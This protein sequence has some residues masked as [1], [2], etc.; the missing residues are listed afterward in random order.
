MKLTANLKNASRAA[1]QWRLLAT[2]IVA[3]LLPTLLLAAPM[4]SS[5]SGIL[6]QSVH[7]PELAKSLDVLSLADIM[8]ELKR[9]SL[10]LQA[11]GIAALVLT[12]LL[13]PLLTGVIVTAGR[14]PETATFRQLF[15]GGV[16][17]YPRMFRTLL[18]A[19]IPLGL[20]LAIGAA[21]AD[22]AQD[23]AEKA[24]LESDADRW[25]LF[26]NVL[27]VLLL[28]LAN[29]TLD[30]GRAQL[31]IDR[32]RTSAVKAWWS[33]LKLLLRRPG[34][35]LGSYALLTVAGL[36]LAGLFVLARFNLAGSNGLLL[37]AGFLLAQLVVL[38]MAWMR[39]ARL[40]A[41]MTLSATNR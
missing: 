12:L 28:A 30:A 10:S 39:A 32:R 5:L 4:W 41:L 23:F 15:A 19:V 34:A 8:A 24:S 11:G 35:M 36:L 33:G 3:A 6:D 7:A 31:A 38:A 29:L 14:A 18:W 9:N 22:S 37:L 27:G 17:E 20:A 40:L 1:L 21:V 16:G 13:S 25:V 26:A 2:W